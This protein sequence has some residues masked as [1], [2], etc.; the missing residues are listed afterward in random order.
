MAH[1]EEKN[2][3]VS[4]QTITTAQNEIKPDSHPTPPCSSLE[5]FFL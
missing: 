3:D 2:K 4:T 1:R 5:T